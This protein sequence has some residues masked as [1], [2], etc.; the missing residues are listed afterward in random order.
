MTI[1]QLEPTS[2][3]TP[4]LTPSGDTLSHFP[5]YSS[6]NSEQNSLRVQRMDFFNIPQTKI[7]SRACPAPLQGRLT[8]LCFKWPVESSKTLG[9]EPWSLGSYSQ[10]N[11]APMEGKSPKGVGPMTQLF[12]CAWGGCF[13]TRSRTAQTGHKLSMLWMLALNLLILYLLSAEITDMP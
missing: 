5:E 4:L 7:P 10:P 13:D 6:L 8:L 1:N 3:R 2:Y 12:F 11:P 9:K